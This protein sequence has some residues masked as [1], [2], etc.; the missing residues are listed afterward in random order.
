MCRIVV[1]PCNNKSFVFCSMS[2]LYKN[3]MKLWSVYFLDTV[4]TLINDNFTGSFTVFGRGRLL[5]EG[6]I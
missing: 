2:S 1:L 6:G 3:C 5:A 4:F